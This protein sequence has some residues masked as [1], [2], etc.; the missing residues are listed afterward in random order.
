MSRLTWDGTAEPVS[1]DQILRRERR[2]VTNMFPC[3]ADHKQD[4]QSYPVD[5]YYSALCDGHTHK[6][7]YILSN[8]MPCRPP[9]F[10]RN[11]CNV[12]NRTLLSNELYVLCR[13]GLRRRGDDRLFLG[14]HEVWPNAIGRKK[15]GLTLAHFAT[16]SIKASLANTRRRPNPNPDHTTS[17]SLHYGILLSSI[18]IFLSSSVAEK[19]SK[20]TVLVPPYF[21]ASFGLTLNP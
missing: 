16:L 12:S 15:H 21:L 3:S 14:S 4:W 9:R 13:G 5:S 17:S 2:Q 20:P 11:I 1:R 19:W 10:W 18:Y 7:T 8:L 6:H